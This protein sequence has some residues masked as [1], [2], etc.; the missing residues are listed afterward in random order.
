MN[1]SL[2]RLRILIVDDNPVHAERLKRM[3]SHLDHEVV[4][5]DD[6]EEAVK[7]ISSGKNLYDPTDVAILDYFMPGINGV[8]LGKKLKSVD[9]DLNVIILTADSSRETAAEVLA[10]NLQTIGY[11]TKKEDIDVIISALNY[12]LAN[13][14]LLLS[15]EISFLRERTAKYNNGSFSK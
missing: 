6:C 13:K 2:L 7:L 14:E 8:E 9:P 5:T 12:A 3:I 1:H 10:A 15:G 4:I 11:I